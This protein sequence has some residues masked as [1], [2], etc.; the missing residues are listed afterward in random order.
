MSTLAAPITLR[1]WCSVGVT[2]CIKKPASRP[3]ARTSVDSARYHTCTNKDLKSLYSERLGFGNSGQNPIQ[4]TSRLTAKATDAITHTLGGTES[5]V[6]TLT[7][8]H[9]SLGASTSSADATVV[10]ASRKDTKTYYPSLTSISA[11]VAQ[12]SNHPPTRGLFD[13]D[14]RNKNGT[15]PVSAFRAAW[16]TADEATKTCYTERSSLLRKKA[17]ASKGKAAGGPGDGSTLP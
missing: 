4:T 10:G 11:R 12:T 9:F 7:N 3:G 8:S 5:Q 6:A 13:I 16:N 1:R 15:A 17:K 14:Y 2:L